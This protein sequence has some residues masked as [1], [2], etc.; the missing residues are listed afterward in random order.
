MRGHD[1]R[2]I[3][4]YRGRDSANGF[5]ANS[6]AVGGEV[7]GGSLIRTRALYMQ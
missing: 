2:R 4:T 6:S 7:G 5:A 3:N 1:R